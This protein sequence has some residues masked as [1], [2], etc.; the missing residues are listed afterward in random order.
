LDQCQCSVPHSTGG[1]PQLVHNTWCLRKSSRMEGTND[2][3]QRLCEVI[4][5]A[6]SALVE[7]GPNATFSEVSGE[8]LKRMQQLHQSLPEE[9]AAFSQ[10]NIM[11]VARVKTVLEVLE[12]CPSAKMMQ[13]ARGWAGA[14][15]TLLDEQGG[16]EA[17]VDRLGM[18]LEECDRIREDVKSFAVEVPPFFAHKADLGEHVAKVL[19]VATAINER[20]QAK[21]VKELAQHQA[22]SSEKGAVSRNPGS[23]STSEEPPVV[24][25]E[26][27]PTHR[28][29]CKRSASEI[30]TT[31]SPAPQSSIK[32]YIPQ[33]QPKHQKQQPPQQQPEPEQLPSP[34]RQWK[35]SSQVVGNPT[36]M[37][38][39][40]ARISDLRG[41]PLNNQACRLI[42]QEPQASRW[43][44]ELVDGTVRPVKI[45]N[46][47][48]SKA[49]DSEFWE[50]KASASAA[51][52][53]A[54]EGVQ[55]PHE[56]V[57]M[58]CPLKPGF[59]VPLK[60]AG[61]GGPPGQ[62]VRQAPE[63]IEYKGY[64]RCFR[65]GD[66]VNMVPEVTGGIATSFSV[67]P[68]LP[69]GLTLDPVSGEIRGVLRPFSESDENTYLVKGMNGGGETIVGLT[70]SVKESI[71]DLFHRDQL[72]ERKVE[73][74]E[75][76]PPHEVA[77]PPA[78][79]AAA[80]A[81]PPAPSASSR[82]I[83]F[84]GPLRA[85]R[86]QW[87]EEEER[88]LIDGHARYGNA[89]ETIRAHCHL[90]HRTGSQCKDKWRNLQRYPPAGVDLH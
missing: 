10:K 40:P 66:M 89:W 29:N 41:D 47:T 81:E 30:S 54:S 84:N 52:A 28:L 19:D 22:T 15:E 48:C 46:L 80:A 90:R 4:E 49:T 9:V 38:G 53:A 12:E 60:K 43:M 32:D 31:T 72:V 63:K 50:L 83:V 70:F 37:V 14:V 2:F 27:R 69:E 35:H 5:A 6:H 26:V 13:A 42:R 59:M 64:K 88:R 68:A 73:R 65:P 34:Q 78:S 61:K 58:P 39:R 1:S 87:T 7:W 51:S 8:H 55:H 82:D 33:Q 71:G 44:V 17:G 57:S 11:L 85:E 45:Q 76:S 21:M 75:S 86:R 18:L 62:V 25:Y 74:I 20:L 23:S 3:G 56:E 77:S 16:A 24:R 79:P 67:E 36:L